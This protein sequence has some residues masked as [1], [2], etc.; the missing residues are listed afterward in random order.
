MKIHPVVNV[1]RVKPQKEKLLGQNS[2]KPGLVLVTEDGQEEFK[3]DFISDSRLT[4][5]KLKFLCQL[6]SPGLFPEFPDCPECGEGGDWQE[7]LRGVGVVRNIGFSLCA[8][9]LYEFCSLISERRV[10]DK[11]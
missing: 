5:G 2:N 10:R 9:P 3:V 7:F 11:S 1:S 4:H 6:L 8:A